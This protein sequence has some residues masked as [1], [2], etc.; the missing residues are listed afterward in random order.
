MAGAGSRLRAV[1]EGVPLQARLVAVLGLAL[2]GA[3]GAMGLS[4]QAILGRYLT[5]HLDQELITNAHGA[6][7]DPAGRFLDDLVSGH[8]RFPSQYVVQVTVQGDPDPFL[9]AGLVTVGPPSP[10]S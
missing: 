7:R 5:D 9:S 6:A 3:L 2:I 1:V 10:G 8:G 4:L